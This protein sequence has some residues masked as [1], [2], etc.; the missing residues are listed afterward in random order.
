[1]QTIDELFEE[2]ETRLLK[3]S[4]ARDAAYAALPKS[5]RDAIE[6]KHAARVA[7]ELHPSRC[8]QIDDDETEE[9]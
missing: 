7:A 6:A 5:E 3:E 9:D 2:E 1:M 8:E 4:K